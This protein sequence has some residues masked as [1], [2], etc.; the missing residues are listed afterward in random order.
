MHRPIFDAQ[1]AKR[2]YTERIFFGDGRVL[3]I[4]YL[5]RRI[6]RFLCSGNFLTAGT[7]LYS[8]PESASTRSFCVYL[9]WQGSLPDATGLSIPLDRISRLCKHTDNNHDQ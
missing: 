2:F 1:K 9:C 4:G 6:V 7:N 3:S 5:S 8:M